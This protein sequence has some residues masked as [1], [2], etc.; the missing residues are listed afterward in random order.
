MVW[1]YDHPLIIVKL[2]LH[3]YA[4]RSIHCLGKC[5]LKWC[6]TTYL[7]ILTGRGAEDDRRTEWS[8]ADVVA[9][10]NLEVVSRQWTK[11]VDSGRSLI[12]KDILDD[13]LSV[14]LRCIRR[15]EQQVT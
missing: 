8:V 13:P 12:F 1:I 6:L 4:I 7:L 2:S 9:R 11:T 3:K 5:P 15:K 10:L 14:W